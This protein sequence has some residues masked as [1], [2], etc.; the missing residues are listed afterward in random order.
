MQEEKCS[1]QW[2]M[3]NV[4]PIFI[5]TEKCFHC[6][7]IVSF[8]TTELNPPHEEY[9][10]GDHFWT[11]MDTAQSISF[12]LKC[13]QCEKVVDYS[14]LLGLMMCTGCDETCKVNTLMRKLE[15]ERTWVYV[16]FGYL[17]VNEV[18]QLSEEQIQYLEDY[19]NQMRKSRQSRIKIVSHEMVDNILNCYAEVIRDVDLL[20]LT[21]P[22]E[23]DQG[24]VR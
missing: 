24:G 2:K 15:S 4:V 10:D 18:E 9:R 5:G 6:G 20:T 11:T 1:H 23:D 17:P 12:D 7:K 13:T 16:A 19:F 3:I 22:E 21:P 8:S 14:Q